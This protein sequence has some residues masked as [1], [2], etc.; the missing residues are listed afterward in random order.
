MENSL[1]FFIINQNNNFF[2]IL[3]TLFHLVM[4]HFSTATVI[5]SFLPKLYLIIMHKIIKNL[6]FETQVI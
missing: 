6:V 1:Y 5:S 4:I 3:F 2:I